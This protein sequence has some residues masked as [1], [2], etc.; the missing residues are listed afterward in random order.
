M[1]RAEIVC[2]NCGTQGKPK[3]ETPGS[4][5]IELILWLCMVVPG[6]IYTI[7]RISKRHDTCPVC[8]SSSIVPAGS[9]AAIR[10]N[11][12]FRP[13]ANPCE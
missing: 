9:P 4:F 6:L 11:Q 2:T 1:A 8:K 7:W 10:I 3:R 12:K 5:L 13:G